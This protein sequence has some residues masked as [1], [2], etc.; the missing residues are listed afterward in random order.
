M[1]AADVNR[2]S[3]N[4]TLE[5]DSDGKI[6]IRFGLSMIKNVG[7]GA[8]E[9]IAGTRDGGFGTQPKF[10]HPTELR[11]LLR[12]GQRFGDTHALDMVRLTLDRMAMGGI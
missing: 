11:L 8:A 9:A 6:G 4:F 3:A 1:L 5:A 12:V 7:S 2:S 10:P